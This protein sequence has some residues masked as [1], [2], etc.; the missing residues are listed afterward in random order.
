MNALELERA[1]ELYDHMGVSTDCIDEDI[2][3]G[4]LTVN[5]SNGKDYVV[6]YDGNDMGAISVETGDTL[7]AEEVERLGI[8]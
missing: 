4:Y 7:G 2:L 6:Y 8:W 3:V 5:E 1:E